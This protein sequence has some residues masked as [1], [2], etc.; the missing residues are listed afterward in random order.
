MPRRKIGIKNG[1]I[2][3]IFNKSIAGYTIFNDS[4]EYVRMLKYIEYYSLA[5]APCPLKEYLNDCNNYS[6]T[7]RKNASVAIIAYCLMPNHFHLALK[8]LNDN[9]VERFMYSVLKNYT[10]YFNYCHNRSGPLW[11][12]RFQNVFV[13]TDEQLLHLT[14][15][16]HLNPVTAHIVNKPGMWKYSSYGEYTG[17]TNTANRICTISP[18]MDVDSTRYADFVNGH[19]DQQREIAMAKRL[20]IE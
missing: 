15:Y 7:S 11:Q 8:E 19:I 9:A 4:S 5:E 14:R 3:H 6:L 18:Y 16:I 2:Y 1:G 10:S 12:S 13:G 17:I 20:Y